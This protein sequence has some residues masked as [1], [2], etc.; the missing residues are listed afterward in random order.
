MMSHESNHAAGASGCQVNGV[1]KAPER[2]ATKKNGCA[3]LPLNGRIIGLETGFAVL[4]THEKSC[5]LSFLPAWAQPLRECGQQLNLRLGLQRLLHDELEAGQER[6]VSPDRLPLKQPVL[7]QLQKKAVPSLSWRQILTF[8]FS[9]V[10]VVIAMVKLAGGCVN[11]AS[12][13]G[14]DL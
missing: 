3:Q 10:V 14:G 7:G 5:R 9:M 4:P 8:I 11:R 13:T 2:G 12:R 1:R 6:F